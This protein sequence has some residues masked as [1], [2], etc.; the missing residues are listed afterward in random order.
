[1]A[2]A[3]SHAAD[4]QATG[5]S[6]QPDPLEWAA[7]FASR[8]VVTPNVAYAPGNADAQ[9]DV[10]V[11]RAA[12]SSAP[13]PVL[14]Y[15]HGGGWRGGLGVRA[16]STLYLLPYL[17][18]GF[19]VVNVDYR[20]GVAPAAVEDAR[21]ALRWVVRNA[22][23]YRIDATKV[24]VAGESS[25]SHLALMTGM[26]TPAAGLDSACPGTDDMKVSAIINWYG[27][28]D[29]PDMLEGPNQQQFA[30]RWLG[31]LPNRA[32]MARVLSPLRH[33]RAGLPAILTVHGDADAVVPHAHAVRLHAV[34]DSVR[35]PNRLVTV[36][37]GGHGGFRRE[38][39]IRAYSTIREFLRAN[40]VLR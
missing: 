28:T 18:M 7:T 29:V 40:G 23:T 17:E 27:V 15:V 3:A 4:A 39:L 24:V 25:G 8:F 32:E 11:P 20:D 9:L 36:P 6:G 26:L 37:G 16:R 14:I 22:A 13:A 2:A 19:A 38:E 12:T 30:T 10:I 1:M 5:A 34:L 35:V 21:C 33:V 31:S